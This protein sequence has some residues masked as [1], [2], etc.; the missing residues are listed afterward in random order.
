MLLNH[1]AVAARLEIVV[2]CGKRFEVEVCP[3][4]GILVSK[5]VRARVRHVGLGLGTMCLYA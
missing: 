2:E 3:F 5:R 4:V 1:L